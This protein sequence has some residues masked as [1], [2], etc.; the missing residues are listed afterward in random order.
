ML[1]IKKKEATAEREKELKANPELVSNKKAE[2]EF[3]RLMEKLDK[4]EMH[5]QKQLN[6]KDLKLE[7][8]KEADKSKLAKYLERKEFIKNE[9]AKIEAEI[10]EIAK[11]EAD[12]WEEYR[13]AK[14]QAKQ[15]KAEY[16]AQLKS[17]KES[18]KSSRNRNNTNSTQS[19]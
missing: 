1:E 15:R 2:T 9:I 18:K 19:K 5:L 4:Q 10:E 11:E 17:E 13:L 7:Q 6:L 16:K 14:K 12:M 3:V 8:T